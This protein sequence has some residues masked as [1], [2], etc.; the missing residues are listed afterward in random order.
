MKPSVLCAINAQ[1][2]CQSI[3]RYEKLGKGWD[4]EIPMSSISWLML[5]WIDFRKCAKSRRCIRITPGIDVEVETAFRCLDWRKEQI[6]CSRANG[7][8]TEGCMVSAPFVE[9]DNLD[10]WHLYLINTSTSSC[11]GCSYWYSHSREFMVLCLWMNSDD[12]LISSWVSRSGSISFSTSWMATASHRV[13]TEIMFH[14]CSRP[15][16]DVSKSSHTSHFARSASELPMCRHR[17]QILPV[18]R[19]LLV[20]LAVR[21]THHVFVHHRMF[22]LI[23][24]LFTLH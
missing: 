23:W 2:T 19:F 5:P 11:S 10:I 18:S 21:P 12:G 6:K 4:V 3:D 13:W 1:V 16:Y 17:P 7:R 22:R 20:K 9:T 8:H 15:G 14:Q 24:Q